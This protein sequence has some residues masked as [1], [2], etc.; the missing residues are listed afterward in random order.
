MRKSA[1]LKVQKQG[2]NETKIMKKSTIVIIILVA[3]VLVLAFVFSNGTLFNKKAGE[4]GK[5]GPEV[6]RTDLAKDAVPAGFPAEIPIEQGAKI[7]T[8]FQATNTEGK[9]Q[10]TRVFESQ[11]TVAQ[12]YK[13]YTD[14]AANYAWKVMGKS[15]SENLSS[16]LL[17]KDTAQLTINI[18]KNTI[19]GVVTVELNYMK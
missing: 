9:L 8:N 10:G 4:T 13:I 14:F 15:E 7:V 19:T 6:K 16:L 1:R 5:K 3:A 11:K 2:I 18:S 17:A 12:N